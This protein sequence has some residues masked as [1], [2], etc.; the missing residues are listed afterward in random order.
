MRRLGLLLLLFTLPAA[1]G[2]AADDASPGPSPSPSASPTPGFTFDPA[3][4]DQGTLR[5]VAE[6]GSIV[7]VDDDATGKLKLVT[8][9]VVIDAP[10]SS[11][12]GVVSDFD[13]LKDFMP[14]VVKSKVVKKDDVAHTR[15]VQFEL[16][17]KFSVI[18]SSIEYVTRFD[19]SQPDR[20]DFQYVSGDIKG[21]GGSYRFIPLDGGTKTL[22]F[23]S[24]IS[25]LKSMGFLTRALLKDQPQMEPAIHVSSASLVVTNL[26]RRVESQQAR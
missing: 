3:G 21:G 18:T 5:T 14:Q 10:P 26:K 23:Y 16:K 15:D 24:V 17:F 13:H 1:L 20:I 11:V 6:R 8:S 9:G 2:R 22:L 25:D 7:I 4:L 19:L 12:Y